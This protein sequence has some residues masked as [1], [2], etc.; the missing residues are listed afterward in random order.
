MKKIM[1]VIPVLLMML[2]CGDG[3]S[4]ITDERWIIEEPPEVI[5]ITAIPGI[6]APVRGAIPVTEV[7]ENDQY[8]G[9]VTWSDS[10][11]AFAGFKVYTATITLTARKGFTL[12]G[13]GENS[14]TVAGAA[15]ANAVN[16][17]IVTAVFPETIPAPGANL[18]YA[19]PSDIS[20][21]MKYVPGGTLSVG[22]YDDVINQTVRTAFWMAETE[23][24]YELWYAVRTWARANG[25][26]LDANPGI[27]GNDGTSVA[28]TGALPTSAKLEPVTM[29]NWREAMVWCNALT[30]YYNANN[31]TAADLDCVYYTDSG[32]IAPIR[33]A[34]D[35]GTILWDPGVGPYD[36]KDDD[37]FVKS[38]AKGFRLS[39]ATEWDCAARYQDGTTWTPGNWASGGTG[40]Y[41]GDAATDYT[42]F[43]PFAWYGGSIT[44]PTGNT[45]TTQ[46][47][48]GKAANALGIYDMSG[49]VWEWCFDW[50]PLNTGSVRVARGGAY[51]YGANTLL[52]G[53]W[54]AKEP[55]IEFPQFGFRFARTH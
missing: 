50:Q 19:L 47:V 5:T 10:P 43:N 37:V 8:E 49:N 25:Y 27:E 11:A 36:G 9:T 55:Y 12:T 15:A 54:G 14:F 29:I 48:A 17:G 1:F 53:L 44:Q 7:S 13:V 31:G 39:G 38:S 18:S 46:P 45:T 30:E 26:T 41:T 24:T 23:V 35:T 2:S 6:T 20:F 42:N 3:L 51:N 40:A 33:T 4:G 21:N 22:P 34:T 16:S 52:L 32:Y 28:G